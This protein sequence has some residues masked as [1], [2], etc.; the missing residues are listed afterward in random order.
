MAW[1][2]WQGHV[3]RSVAAVVQRLHEAAVE[4]VMVMW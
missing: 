2:E 1:R 3:E 4:C